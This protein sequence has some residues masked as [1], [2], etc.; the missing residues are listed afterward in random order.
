MHCL[1]CHRELLPEEE[2]VCL[3]CLLSFPLVNSADPQ[4]PLWAKL[5]GQIAFEHATTFAYYEHGDKFTM[6]PRKA[7][8]EG[9]PRINAYLTRQ[10][11]QRLEGSGW[12]Y[13]IDAIIPVPIHWTR[14]LQRGYNQA[15]PIAR[16][17]S[18]AWHIPEET[19]CLKRVKSMR[20]QL[21]AEEAERGDI[22]KEVFKV[23]HPERLKGKHVL[24]VD[25]ICTTGSTLCACG[26]ELLEVSGLRL[27]VLTL[28][29]TLSV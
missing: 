20:S 1:C 27:S 24:L 15:A 21:K 8:Y 10:L 23:R 16:T 25:D 3:E 14:L 2:F 12:P 6:L 5:S 18:K 17:L 13:D 26:K 9:Q 19:S 28:G 4:N 11:L 7:K 22:F 29:M